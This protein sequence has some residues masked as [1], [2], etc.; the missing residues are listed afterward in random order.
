MMELR[1][2]RVVHYGLG[3]IGSSIARLTSARAPTKNAAT[4]KISAVR[5]KK[6]ARLGVHRCF[7]VTMASISAATPPVRWHRA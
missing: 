3:A 1:E 4:G 7:S 6:V 5:I 2:I